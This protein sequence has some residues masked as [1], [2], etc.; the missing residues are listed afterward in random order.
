MRRGNIVVEIDG[1]IGR[2]IIDKPDASNALAPRDVLD[3]A[4]AYAEIDA[5]GTCNVIILSGNGKGFCA[6]HDLRQAG[7]DR[8]AQDSADGPVL[9]DW[10]ALRRS[11][12]ALLRI[13]DGDTPVLAQVHGYCLGSGLDLMLM[14]DLAVTTTTCRFSHP[15][16]RSAGG[17]PSAMAYPAWI[18]AARAK[19]FLWVTPQLSGVEAESW[20]MVNKA[21]DPAELER[22][23]G[24][25]AGRI[26]S[27]P[28]DNITIQRQHLRR[29]QDLAGF[30]SA[31]ELGPDLDALAHTSGA[32][33]AWREAV[34]RHG[35]A[36]AVRR[37]DQ[38]FQTGE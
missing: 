2:L 14:C 8:A 19:E 33:V 21:V 10:S 27:L 24:T 7:A 4:A 6:G 15:A 25:W 36:E 32:T 22:T 28:K 38:N 31:I 34:D 18:G 30:R 9:A 3:L 1:R 5:S 16:I 26:A 35:F 23:V 29:I 17:T 11:N 20:G 12:D 13:R 37:R